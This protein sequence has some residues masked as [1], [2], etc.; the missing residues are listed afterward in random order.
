LAAKVYVSLPM[1]KGT[2]KIYTMLFEEN[3]LKNYFHMASDMVK[4]RAGLNN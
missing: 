4:Q 3:V 2:E 1:L